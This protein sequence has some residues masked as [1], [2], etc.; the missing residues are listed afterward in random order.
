MNLLKKL[1]AFIATMFA[2]GVFGTL[3]VSATS[4]TDTATLKITNIEGNPTVKLYKIGTGEYNANNDSFIKF[5]YENGVSLTETG[6]TSQEITKIANDINKGIISPTLV[7]TGNATNGTYTY[8]ATG[9]GVYIAILT[10]ATDGRTYNP[11][12]L[13]ASYNGEGILKGGEVSSKANYLY[14]QTTVAKS[15]LPSIKKEVSNTTKDGDKDTASVGQE[16]TYKLTVQLPSY[17]ENASNKTVFVSDEMSEG[18]TFDYTSLTVT[19]GSK[20]GKIDITTNSVSIDGKKIANVAKTANGFRLNFDYDNLDSTTSLQVT[21]KA[22]V[23][24]KAVVGST[25]NTNTANYYYASNPT[26]GETHKTTDEPAEG[27]GLTKK[28]DSRKV[29]T[30]RIAFKKTGQNKTALADA[31]FGI[32]ADQNAT[33][34]IDIVKT[35]NKG[36]ATSN[37]VGAG[38]YYI[39][40]MKAP[41]GYSLNTKVYSVEAK[42]SSVTASTVVTRTETIYTTNESEKA[43]GSSSVGWLKNGNY[44]K[45]KIDGA[46]EAYIK[47]TT[48]ST[49]TTSTVELNKGEGTGTAVLT[50]DIPNTKL[51]ELPSTG[52]IGTLLFTMIGVV[53]MAATAG[54]YVLKHKKS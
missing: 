49:A 16:L 13:A 29:Y 45:Q 14:G 48:G 12:L 9:A 50:T 3:N 33:R 36:Y 44:Y 19:M 28:E 15:T 27:N 40:E 18:L 47:S 6:P 34:L 42:W 22:V 8:Q 51:G 32:Y 4:N 20:I 43:P 53:V 17:S 41:K 37:Q 35:N 46:Q 21:Y 30:Y 1:V 10:G 11:V 26:Q 2:V 7:N 39:K 24:E 23:N 52:G 54:I 25:G 31:V 5:K 38:T